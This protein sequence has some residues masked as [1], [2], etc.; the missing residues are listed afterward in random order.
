[1][2]MNVTSPHSVSDTDLF[3]MSYNHWPLEHFDE[4]YT[5][6]TAFL[7]SDPPPSGA[8]SSLPP[9]ERPPFAHIADNSS[10]AVDGTTA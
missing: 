10:A 1:M 8:P 9:R 3:T 4:V 5:V 7:T 2:L 6:F